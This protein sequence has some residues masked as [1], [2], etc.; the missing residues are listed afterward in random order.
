MSAVSC[1]NEE[2]DCPTTLHKQRLPIYYKYRDLTLHF[3]AKSATQAL[4]KTDV[5]THQTCTPGRHRR[6]FA[7][8]CTPSAELEDQL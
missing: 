2:Y 8:A 1:R 6:V 7:N 3:C 4:C 5:S